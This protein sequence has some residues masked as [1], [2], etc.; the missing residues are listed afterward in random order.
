LVG[1]VRS[2]YAPD[3]LLYAGAPVGLAS[4]AMLGPGDAQD[5]ILAAVLSETAEDRGV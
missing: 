4:A 5:L 3:Q 1:R 2:Y